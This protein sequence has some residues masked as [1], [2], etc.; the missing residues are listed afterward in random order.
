MGIVMV[1]FLFVLVRYVMMVMVLVMMILQPSLL[2]GLL[3]FGVEQSTDRGI[4]LF[5]FDLF[6]FE[7]NAEALRKTSFRDGKVPSRCHT[8]VEVLV[9][10]EEPR[11]NDRARLPIHLHGFVVFQIFLT[12]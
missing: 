2:P 10:P 4:F 8:D 5:L 9:K 6:N 3:Q 11:G 1:A 7:R 12:G